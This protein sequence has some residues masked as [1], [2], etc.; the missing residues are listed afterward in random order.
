MSAAVAALR[1]GGLPA[2]AHLAGEGLGLA[3]LRHLAAASAM[4]M[5]PYAKVLT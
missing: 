1:P 4:T 5:A 2:V 3:D